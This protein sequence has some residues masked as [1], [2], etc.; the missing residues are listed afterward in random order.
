MDVVVSTSTLR[1][2]STFSVSSLS[3]RIQNVLAQG[4]ESKHRQT[5][6]MIVMVIIPVLAL[7]GCTAISTTSALKTYMTANK[8]TEQLQHLLSVSTSLFVCLFFVFL[9]LFLLKE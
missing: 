4:I 5:F 9:Y 2:I 7:I 3:Y 1:R 6:K 8:A